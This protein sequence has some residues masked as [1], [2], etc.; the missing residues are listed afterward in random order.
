MDKIESFEKINILA[1]NIRS[2]RK[3]YLTNFFPN[4]EKHTLWIEKE[5]LFFISFPGCHFLL[6]LTASVQN[7]FFIAATEEELTKSLKIFLPLFPQQL[8]VDI[9]GNEK[10]INLKEL[11]LNQGFN[12]YET[13]YR[14]SRTG[15]V[16]YNEAPDTRVVFAEKSDC[17]PLLNM[18]HSFFNPLSEQLPCYE[19]IM[20]FITNQRVLVFRDA[21][22]IC[23][24]IIFEINGM[25]LYLRYWFVLPEYRDKKIGAKLF[26]EFLRAGHDTQRQLFWVIAHNENAIKRYLHYGF[27]PEKIFDYVLLKPAT[28]NYIL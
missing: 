21:G 26:N 3:G 9:V 4:K 18:L 16:K 25:T 22:K 1:N 6:H 19:E 8:V 13:L 5:E 7:L 23:G 11:F 17:K 20:D 24:F 2:L 27:N 10:T 15:A 12:E 14:M 28:K